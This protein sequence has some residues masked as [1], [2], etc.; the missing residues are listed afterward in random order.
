MVLVKER[1]NLI[2]KEKTKRAK[3]ITICDDTIAD[4]QGYPI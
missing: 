4:L 2:A 3:K 1:M